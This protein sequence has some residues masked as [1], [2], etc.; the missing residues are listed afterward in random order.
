MLVAF[1]SLLSGTSPGTCLARA[2]A[3]FL[4]FSGFGLILRFALTEMVSGEKQSDIEN[5]RLDIIIPGTTV[6]DVLK[7]R[8]E[9]EDD[10]SSS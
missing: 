3:A 5:S 6:Q 1:L 10:S 9:K 7:A 2:G 8:G 4:V